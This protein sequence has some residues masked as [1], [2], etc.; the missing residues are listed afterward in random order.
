MDYIRT[1]DWVVE[2]IQNAKERGKNCSLLIGAGC[3]EKAGIPTATGF[4]D[5][6]KEAYPN[7]YEAAESKTYPLCME[8]LTSA[9]QHDLIAKYVNNAKINWAHICMAQLMKTNYVDRILTTNFDLLVVKACALLGEFPAIYDL[10]VTNRF[11]DSYIDDKAVFYLHGQ[12]TGFTQIH[13]QEEFDRHSQFIQPAFDDAARKRVWIVIGYSGENDPV[14]D[15]LAKIPRFENGLYWIGYQNDTPPKHV[16][17]KLLI[18]GKQAFYINCSD[19]DS[20][21][22]EFTQKLGIFPPDFVVKPFSHLLGNLDSL[23]PF[24]LPGQSTEQD[25]TSVTRQRIQEAISKYEEE[26]PLI[27]P[28]QLP[29]EAAEVAEDSLIQ[30]ANLLLMSGDYNGV[31]ALQ[32][33]LKGGASPKLADLISWAYISQG[34]ALFDQ[35]KM[36]S[37]A[38]ADK[39]FAQVWEKYKAAL[40]I[41]PDKHE[42]LYNWGNALSDQANMKSGEEADRLFSLA[43]EKYKAALDIKPDNHGALNNWGTALSDQAKMKSGAEADNLFAQAGEKYQAALAFKPDYLEAFNNWGAIL[44]DQAK[45]KGGEEAIKLFSQ[46]GEKLIECENLKPGWGSY[47]LACIS[48]L[49]G[50][51]ENC[52]EWLAKSKSHKKLPSKDHLMQDTDLD[53]VRQSEWFKKFLEEAYP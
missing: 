53:N 30:K 35:A 41:K 3:S 2:K 40:D 24:L 49:T 20:F 32:E 19:A 22:V 31:I 9:E 25:V 44:S 16:R 51:D 47:D 45:M 38:E 43:S 17:E 10:A 4:V 5:A 15:Q 7:S 8:Q 36:K 21:L 27:T 12:L 6:I 26:E 34:N 23:A 28:E 46:A 29:T 11:V 39:L 52:R 13:T 18:S 1:I 42:A 14:F 48:A 37:G 50:R 33:R